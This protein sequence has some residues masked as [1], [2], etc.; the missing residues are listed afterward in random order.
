MLH[1]FLSLASLAPYS[2]SIPSALNSPSSVSPLY[3]QSL[4]SEQLSSQQPRLFLY[5]LTSF[6]ESLKQG[7]GNAA[8][9]GSIGL[10]IIPLSSSVVVSLCSLLRYWVLRDNCNYI[11]D[12]II[13]TYNYE[14]LYTCMILD[15]TSHAFYIPYMILCLS[16]V[17]IINKLF[18]IKTISAYS[19]LYALTYLVTAHSTK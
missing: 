14:C 11:N 5:Y 3:P 18:T 10:I 9:L 8:G 13:F 19:A 15:H 6:C 2:P 1:L 16:Y 12:Y 17:I 4:R 7:E